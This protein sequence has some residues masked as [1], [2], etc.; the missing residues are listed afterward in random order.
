MSDINAVILSGRLVRDPEL[1]YTTGGTAIAEFTI[2]SG[3]KYKGKQGEIKE[4]T[5]FAGCSVFGPMA[6][7]VGKCLRKGARANVQGI[8]VTESW[9]DKQTGKNKS[10]TRVKATQVQPIDWANDDQGERPPQTQQAPPDASR[11]NQ[12]QNDDDVPF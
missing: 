3:R 11:N 1:R 6:D 10:R 9:E 7:F 4:E 12:P 5:T 2:A 8:L